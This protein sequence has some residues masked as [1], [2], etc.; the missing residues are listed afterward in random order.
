MSTIVRA[1]AF[2]CL[3]L[4]LAIVNGGLRE[5][6]LE[7]VLGTTAGYALSGALLS[8]CVLLVALL[9]AGRLGVRDPAG[10]WFVGLFWLGL[11]V[12]V[13]FALGLLVLRTPPEEVLAQYTFTDGNLWP[14][15]LIVVAVSPRLA[16]RLRGLA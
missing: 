6:L 9:A 16:A 2:W 4:L 15:V 11:T 3:I 5:W 12:I 10:F 7:P 1:S 14:L 8:A 13:E